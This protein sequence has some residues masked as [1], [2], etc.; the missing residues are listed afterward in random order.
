MPDPVHTHR[1]V[2]TTVS[3]AVLSAFQCL[4]KTGKPQGHEHTVLAGFVV[5]RTLEASMECHVVAIGTGTK[6]LS[7]QK[8]T[9][10]GD[11][12]NDSHAEVI[13]KRALQ[14]W[15]Y[16]ELDAAQTQAVYDHQALS[17][18]MRRGGLNCAME[19]S[20]TCLSVSLPAVMPASSAQICNLSAGSPPAQYQQIQHA[21]SRLQYSRQTSDIQQTQ[22]R[23]SRANLQNKRVL[24]GVGYTPGKDQLMHLLLGRRLI[25]TL[26]HAEAPV[27][28]AC[29][30]P[31]FLLECS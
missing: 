8:R 16:G 18:W 13:A 14:V 6:C 22:Q 29:Q 3:S 28:C 19:S 26:Q 5:S 17:T 25:A 4:P 12:I 9:C 24:T 10:Q 15:L 1:D 7:A 31:P 21:H 2:G 20:C 23:C 11:L 30:Q 27:V